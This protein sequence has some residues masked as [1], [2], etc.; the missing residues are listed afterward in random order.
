MKKLPLFFLVCTILLCTES[1]CSKN[2]TEEP[3]QNNTSVE[4]KENNS[5]T[6]ALH[7]AALGDSYTLG[8]GIPKK[9][10]FP[11]Q[12]RISLSAQLNRWI[13]LELLAANGWRTDNLLNQLP[14]LNREAYDLVTLLIGVNNQ[15]Q[16]LDDSQFTSEFSELL[17]NA[18][19]LTNNQP[20]RVVVISI[21]DYT[22]SPFGRIYASEEVSAQIDRWND[23][24]ASLAKQRGSYFIDIIDISRKGLESPE[25][26]GSDGLHLSGLAYSQFAGRIQPIVYAE[27]SN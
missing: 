11:N 17:D 9:D 19:V 4:G 26:I 2:E 1:S 6:A 21:P 3:L 8:T 24:A 7:Y 5:E 14:D 25:L 10:S 18:I 27:L 16:G 20:E 23:F 15:F 13:D 12:L 22:F